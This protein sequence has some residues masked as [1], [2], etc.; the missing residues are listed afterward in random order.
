MNRYPPLEGTSSSPVGPGSSAFLYKPCPTFFGGEVPAVQISP[1]KSTAKIDE[2]L[3]H[4]AWNRRWRRPTLFR[5]GVFFPPR[6]KQH[7]GCVWATPTPNSRPRTSC[8]VPPGARN[9]VVGRS[10]LLFEFRRTG[11]PRIN[12]FAHVT[13]AS[14]CRGGGALPSGRST[15][16]AALTKGRPDRYGGRI[17]PDHAA[18][19]GKFVTAAFSREGQ[20]VQIRF[21][22]WPKPAR[23]GLQ[24]KSSRQNPD[25]LLKA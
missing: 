23:Q 24:Q 3:R 1:G 12:A 15:W 7:Q 13:W 10:N 20:T 21:P 22:R 4:G 11:S 6:N 17:I 5:T 14:I 19:Q 18:R 9:Y 16:P 8:R 2:A 25:L